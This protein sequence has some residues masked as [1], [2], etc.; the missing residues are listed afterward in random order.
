MILKLHHVSCNIQQGSLELI[1]ELFEIFG[2]NISYRKGKERW[3]MI[4]QKPLKFDIQLIETKEKILKTTEKLN[5][6]I[7]FIS[8][9]PKEE[10]QKI[11]TWANS[12]KIDFVT[13]SWSETEH[14]FDLP[15]IFTNFVIEV[16]HS[17]ID[18]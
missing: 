11:I 18:E 8:D 10:I 1:I 14:W 4:E 7:C 5:T 13:G 12:K 15:K 9:N 16:M 3:A 17:S 2:C 6:H